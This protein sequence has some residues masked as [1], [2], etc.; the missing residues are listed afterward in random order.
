MI[1]N[2]ILMVT[3]E[4]EGMIATKVRPVAPPRRGEGLG[5]GDMGWGGF[6]VHSG[7]GCLLYSQLGCMHFSLN[8]QYFSN[9]KEKI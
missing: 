2:L 6:R 7:N 9:F 1:L 3:E 4:K 8:V 5:L